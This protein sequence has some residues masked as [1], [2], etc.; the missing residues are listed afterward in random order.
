MSRW[1]EVGLS[2]AQ[3]HPLY[4]RSG[5]LAFW[6]AYLVFIGFG[7][8]VFLFFIMAAL[9]EIPGDLTPVILLDILFHA[10]LIVYLGHT[11]H[12]GL[13]K[14]PTPDGSFRFDPGFP[15]KI[16][17]FA[18]LAVLVQA[19]DAI[20][21]P[22]GPE[23]GNVFALTNAIVNAVVIVLYFEFSRRVHITYR[24]EVAGRDPL[25]SPA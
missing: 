3:T 24:H 2:P 23:L 8:L 20:F 10:I 13:R 14:I 15:R 19:F 11:L 5:W 7:I 9:P 25:L 1:H 4:G 22:G 21:V 16:V 17:V 18:G 6:F 12:S